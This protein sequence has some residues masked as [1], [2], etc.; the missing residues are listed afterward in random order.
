MG[1]SAIQLC[2]MEVSRLARA[3]ASMHSTAAPTAWAW[4]AVPADKNY[5]GS[6]LTL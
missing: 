4:T 6:R 3:H 2:Q 5:T 1:C